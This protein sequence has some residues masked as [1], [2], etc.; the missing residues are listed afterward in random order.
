VACPWRRA[1]TE[2]KYTWYDGQPTVTNN[3]KRQDLRIQTQGKPQA[4]INDGVLRCQSGGR[5][6]L[7]GSRP[8]NKNS[9]STTQHRVQHVADHP[10]ALQNSQMPDSGWWTLSVV[11]A[12]HTHPTCGMQA[13]AMIGS[14]VGI[15]PA[16][17]HITRWE[18]IASSTTLPLPCALGARPPP[19]PRPPRRRLSALSCWKTSVSKNAWWELGADI[20]VGRW[21]LGFAGTSLQWLA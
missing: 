17:T 9:W 7:S 8:P 20:W 3:L 19:A 13:R 12:V 5:P 21:C 11:Q 15:S 4:E 1:G 2:S 6:S 16:A 18:L 14:G 10:C